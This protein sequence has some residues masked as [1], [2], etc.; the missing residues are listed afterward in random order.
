LHDPILEDEKLQKVLYRGET[1][2]ENLPG[3]EVLVTGQ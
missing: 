2:L 1:Y 3:F